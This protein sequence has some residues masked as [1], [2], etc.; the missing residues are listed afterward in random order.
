MIVVLAAALGVGREAAKETLR[1]RA[2]DRSMFGSAGGAPQMTGGPEGPV[3][4]LLQ[5][6]QK[7]GGHL[8]LFLGLV[9]RC[10]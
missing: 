10:L 5:R 9:C 4:T 8:F 3:N 1:R 7:L 6:Q 2:I